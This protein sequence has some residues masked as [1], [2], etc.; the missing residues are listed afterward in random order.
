[1]DMT[2][3][4]RHLAPTI[5]EDP[6]VDSHRIM[7]KKPGLNI[8]RL[9]CICIVCVLVLL[10]LVT[11]SYNTVFQDSPS[12]QHQ[13]SE[14]QHNVARTVKATDG[15][16][17]QSNEN[18]WDKEQKGKNQFDHGD[19]KT[20]AGDKTSPTMNQVSDDSSS[21]KNAENTDPSLDGLLADGF[22]TGS[23]QSRDQAYQYRKASKHKPSAYL[24]ERLRKYEAL[25]RKCG[26]NTEFFKNSLDDLKSGKTP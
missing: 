10:A 26:P 19:G 2:R 18:E 3:F 22:S 17:I 1:M 5:F 15:V 25:H 12:G 7:E 23:C 8:T 6:D 21:V 14:L 11:S 16:G 9:L 20:N 24:L 4:R 13:I